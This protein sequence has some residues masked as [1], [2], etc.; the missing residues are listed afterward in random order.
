MR[1]SRLINSELKLMLDY[2]EVIQGRLV[3][4]IDNAW[5]IVETEEGI[6]YVHRKRIVYMVKLREP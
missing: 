5:L 1:F 2:D 3:D 4:V 6:A